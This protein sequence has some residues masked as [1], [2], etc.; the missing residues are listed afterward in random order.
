VNQKDKGI[1]MK[2]YALLFLF[3]FLSRLG[4]AQ[5][6]TVPEKAF[7]VGVRV[8]EK[9]PPFRLVSQNG[10]ELDFNAVKGPKGLALLFFRSADW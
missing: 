9:I 3:L 7:D 6:V 8:G 1:E 4:F 10:K 2:S 5:E